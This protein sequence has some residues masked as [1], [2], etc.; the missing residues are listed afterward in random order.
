M[1]FADR[2]FVVG[3]PMNFYRCYFLSAS[4]AIKDVAEFCS[5]GDDEALAHAKGLLMEQALYRGFE[6]W[7][8]RR[9][10]SEIASP[11]SD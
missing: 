4:N 1:S 3:E 6:L 10:H 8:S 5:H 11:P 2:V 7:G 9:V